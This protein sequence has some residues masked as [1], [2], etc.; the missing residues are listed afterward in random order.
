MQ[1][2]ADVTL[3]QKLFERWTQELGLPLKD[4]V[5]ELEISRFV[6]GTSTEFFLIES[7]EPIDFTEETT[8]ELTQRELVTPP[9]PFPF[10]EF[11][12]ETALG[13]SLRRKITA[14]EDLARALGLAETVAV[15]VEPKSALLDVAKLGD[16]LEVHVQGETL[17]EKAAT[18]EPLLLVEAVGRGNQRKL[19]VYSVSSVPASARGEVILRSRKT[20]EI[21]FTG[22]S[23]S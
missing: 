14:R 21:E 7:P 13:R 11:A 1:A 23:S 3:R 15:D 12:T 6:N 19:N 22:G 20:D 18:A 2:N 5:N 10:F 4:E 8:I 9:F 16:E 17:A